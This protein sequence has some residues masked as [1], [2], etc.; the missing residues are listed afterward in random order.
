MTTF[1]IFNKTCEALNV[2]LEA[3][4]QPSRQRDLVDARQ[5]A[6]YVSKKLT[7][8][9]L[10]LIGFHIGRKD[11]STVLHAIKHVR[12]LREAK[13]KIFAEKYNIIAEKF[14]L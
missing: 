12:N 11:H 14:K 5:L 8:D 6:M 1:E 9:P 10:R 3:A 7:K 4:S 2:D 13:D